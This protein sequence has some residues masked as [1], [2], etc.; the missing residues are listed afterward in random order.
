[1]YAEEH[2][3]GAQN[4]DDLT[5]SRF[6]I[7]EEKPVLPHFAPSIKEAVAWFT[8]RKHP[9]DGYNTIW[10]GDRFTY[11]CAICQAKRE[12]DLRITQ[13]ER[14]TVASAIPTPR[15]IVGWRVVEVESELTGKGIPTKK[16]DEY[17]TLPVVKWHKFPNRYLCGNCARKL[18]EV[19][20]GS[21]AAEAYV[22][23][24]E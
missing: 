8:G 1:F 23:E 14:L 13:V 12:V 17:K 16:L 21:E 2:F 7:L 3:Q 5:F 10:W 24:M 15:E 18:A 19:G 4:P 22:F 20:R 9:K 11:G 6:F